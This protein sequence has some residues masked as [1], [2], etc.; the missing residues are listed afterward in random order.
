M[1]ACKPSTRTYNSVSVLRFETG[2]APGGR[3]I[4]ALVQILENSSLP[5]AGR[6]V[7]RR[8]ALVDD[9]DPRSRAAH[10][11]HKDGYVLAVGEGSD[12]ALTEDDAFLF[13]VED[14]LKVR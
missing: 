2:R 12:F 11:I 7:Q 1:C 3:S 6:D 4:E 13:V 5:I 10:V 8:S 14:K 9:L